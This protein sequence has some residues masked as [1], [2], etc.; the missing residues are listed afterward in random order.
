LGRP[1]VCET[2]TGTDVGKLV[3]GTDVGLV[4]AIVSEAVLG[5]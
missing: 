5:C 4:G 2:V 1:L 3:L